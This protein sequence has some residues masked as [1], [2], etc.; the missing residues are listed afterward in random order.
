MLVSKARGNKMF[1]L[2]SQ[3]S[4]TGTNTLA[5]VVRSSLTKKE[6]NGSLVTETTRN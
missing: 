5:Y 2:G 1:R 6:K 4:L 3:K